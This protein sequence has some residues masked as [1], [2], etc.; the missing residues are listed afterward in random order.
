MP[1]PTVSERGTAMNIHSITQY[2]RYRWH[3]HSRHGIHSPFA[4]AFI[5][6]VLENRKHIQPSDTLIPWPQQ[7]PARYDALLKRMITYY[8]HDTVGNPFS[9]NS[10]AKGIMLIGHD[11]P[12][13]W[14]ATV[15]NT[16][17][18]KEHIVVLTGIHRSAAHTWSWNDVCNETAV[19]MSMDLYDIG[20]LFFRKEFLVKQHFVLRGPK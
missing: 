8:R 4:Y 1:L 18:H 10:A 20:L 15:S 19:K 16:P 5:E 12:A 14:A 11:C 7:T 2:I 17:F 13:A 3:A 6:D 9:I